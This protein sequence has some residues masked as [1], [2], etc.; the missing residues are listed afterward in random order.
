[1]ALRVLAYRRVWALVRAARTWQACFVAELAAIESSI[2]TLKMASRMVS[3][4]PALEISV[5]L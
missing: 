5:Q 4:Q 2:A 3:Q 1:M